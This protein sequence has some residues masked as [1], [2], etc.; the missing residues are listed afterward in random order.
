MKTVT[1]RGD[2]A[3]HGVEAPTPLGDR[4]LGGVRGVPP[5]PGGKCPILGS[6]TLPHINNSNSTG[7]KTVISRV[8]TATPG[9]E[10]PTLLADR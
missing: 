9:V 10:T 5:H 3:A 7:T 1:P 6:E 2:T 8:Y 4:G